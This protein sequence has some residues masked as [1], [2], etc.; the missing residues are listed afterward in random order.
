MDITKAN[1]IPTKKSYT[2][3]VWPVR[4]ENVVELPPQGSTVTVPSGGEN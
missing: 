4:A 1:M 2:T 3:Y